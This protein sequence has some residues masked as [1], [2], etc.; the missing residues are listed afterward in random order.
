MGASASYVITKNATPLSFISSPGGHSISAAADVE[1]P[2]GER[3]TAAFG[4]AR[5][6]QS[7]G[8]LSVISANPNSDREFVS[9]SY[10]FTRPL[11]R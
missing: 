5:L 10:Q 7:Y 2:I 8:G 6:H 3:W 9:I 1:H 11:G 4:F